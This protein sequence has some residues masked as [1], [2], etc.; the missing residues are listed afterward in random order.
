MGFIDYKKN[1][2]PVDGSDFNVVPVFSEKA[3][4]TEC[5]V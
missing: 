4:H 2:L 1:P 3:G 5:Y